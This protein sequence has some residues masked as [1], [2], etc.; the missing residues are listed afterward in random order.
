MTASTILSQLKFPFQK[1][2]IE[3]AFKLLWDEA[4]LHLCMTVEEMSRR[5]DFSIERVL[6]RLNTI[7]NYVAEFATMSPKKIK[8]MTEQNTLLIDNR[9][10]AVALATPLK[11]AAYLPDQEITSFLA[12]ITRMEKLLILGDSLV[13]SMITA[14]FL[15]DK[16]VKNPRMFLIGEN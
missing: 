4:D 12:T 7:E 10:R 1:L 9:T 6:A 8:S 5:C 13:D 16:G 2:I 3:Q 15:R 11:K 14:I